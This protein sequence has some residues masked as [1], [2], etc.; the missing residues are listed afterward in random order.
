MVRLHALVIVWLASGTALLADGPDE[1]VADALNPSVTCGEC[2][3]EIYQMWR[4]SMHSGAFTDPIFETSYLRA[5][6]ATDGEAAVLCMRCHAPAA[7]STQDATLQEALTREG[8][9]C[10]FCHSIVS[11]DLERRD[12]PFTLKIDGVKRG[13][14]AD[15]ESPAHEVAASPLHESSELCAGCHEYTSERGVSIMSTYSEWKASPQA[16]QGV[17]CQNCHM[18]LG[19]GAVAR[20]GLGSSRSMINLHN[21]SGGHSRDQVRKAATVKILSVGRE[22]GDSVLV[23]V[24]VSNTGAGHNIP[25][26]MPTRRLTLDVALYA[27]KREVRR[28]QRYY[29]KSLVDAGGEILTDD[30][31][32]LLDAESILE[33]TRLRPGEQRIEKFYATVSNRRAVLKAE[34]SLTYLYRPELMLRQEMSI[35]IGSDRFSPQE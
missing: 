24:E 3:Q 15:S 5:F 12:V 6:E 14:L 10:D 16:A 1:L 30:H 35:D 34:A 29:Q 22:I 4:R 28:F 33:D 11:V 8:V 20:P 32:V 25:T 23:E 9:T 21:I 31:R 18:P 7:V 13:P 17:T 26:G 27:G 2:H 19:P